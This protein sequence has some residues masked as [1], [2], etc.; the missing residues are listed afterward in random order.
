MWICV[1]ACACR[2][3]GAP[4]Y[5]FVVSARIPVNV[6]SNKSR[7]PPNLSPWQTRSRQGALSEGLQGC[8]SAAMNHTF[9]ITIV[10]ILRIFTIRQRDHRKSISTHIPAHH[11]FVTCPLPAP[12]CC[13]IPRKIFYVYQRDRRAIKSQ[14]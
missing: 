13:G 7:Q 6:K 4:P 9:S 1:H 14:P 12:V 3:A 5:L 8:A 11:L 10:N 2:C